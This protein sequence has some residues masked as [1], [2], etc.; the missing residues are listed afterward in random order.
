[1]DDRLKLW[2]GEAFHHLYCRELDEA[3]RE[4]KLDLLRK[5][6]WLSQPLLRRL[7]RRHWQ[8][9][10]PAVDTHIVLDTQCYAMRKDANG[11]TWLEVM[12]LTPR[13]RLAIPLASRAPIS[14][15]MRLILCGRNTSGKGRGQSARGGKLEIHYAVPEASACATRPCG[16]RTLGADKGYA[17]VFTDSDGD[18]HGRELGT[19][20]TAKSD[21]NNVRYQ[22][23]Q[24]LAAIADKHRVKRRCRKYERI[25]KNNLGRKKS[26]ARRRVIAPS[27]APRCSPPPMRSSIRPQ[28]WWKKIYP[29][30]S[31]VTIAA[32]VQTAVC[33]AGS[34]GSSEKRLARFPPARSVGGLHQRS[35][36]FANSTLSP[37]LRTA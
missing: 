8:R 13:G 20:L 32:K 16:T 33:R 1:M 37:V 29:A 17:E 9:G 22:G 14:G 25:V 34:R 5:D 31:W 23:R 3:E 27:F 15:T 11:K 2:I 30:R 35:V 12:G 24:T 19:L 36:Y 18:R 7:M 26:D 21:A 28:C 10:K 4:A 6:A